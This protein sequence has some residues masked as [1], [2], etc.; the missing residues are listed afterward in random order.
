MN[1]TL[2]EA[3]LNA[4]LKFALDYRGTPVLRC[5]RTWRWTAN[6]LDNIGGLAD[7]MTRANPDNTDEVEI[8]ELE[9]QI[10]ERA[11][12]EPKTDWIEAI[13]RRKYSAV[14]QPEWVMGFVKAVL[15]EHRG[16]G[17]HGRG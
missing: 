14:D 2:E 17:L 6:R 12:P 7:R 11:D 8:R 10:R 1:N 13:L 4:G 3:G 5:L 16:L 9:E 15:G